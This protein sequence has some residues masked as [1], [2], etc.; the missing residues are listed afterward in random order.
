MAALEG[1]RIAVTGAGG[2]IG[3]VLVRHLAAQGAR[4]QAISRQAEV[5]AAQSVTAWPQSAAARAAALAGCDAVVHLAAVA[6]AAAM[7]RAGQEAATFSPNLQLTQEV[8]QACADAGVP[9]LVLAS[10]IGVHGVRTTDRPFRAGDTPAPVEPYAASKLACEQ[11]A[12]ASAERHGLALVIVRPPLVHGADAPGNFGALWQAVARGRWLPLGAIENRRSLVG[13]DN[14]ADLLALCTVHPAAAGQV[15]L[16]S[17]G[18][19][20]STPE[21]VRRIAQAQGRPARLLALPLPLLR[22]LGAATGRR[23]AVDR[24]GW[25]LE[26]DDRPTRGLLAWTPPLSLDQGL[27]RAARAGAAA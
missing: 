11:A 26:V 14:L 18:P 17:D 15:L 7:G 23:A 25:S 13:V 9:R 5:P 16:V 20:V 6:H 4:V 3:R 10:S 27:L 22:L 12:Q 1:R 8:A 19:S 2:F 24:L 21:L